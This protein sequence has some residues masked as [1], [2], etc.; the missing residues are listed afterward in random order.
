M[1]N[2]YLMRSRLFDLPPADALRLL[3]AMETIVR[4]EIRNSERLAVLCARIRV[5]DFIPRPSGTNTAA[6]GCSGASRC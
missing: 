6:R 3:A 4:Q 5:W 2:F 1:L